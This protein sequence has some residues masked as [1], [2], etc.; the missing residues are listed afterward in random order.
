M[1]RSDKAGTESERLLRE[2][3]VCRLG[4]AAIG[5]GAE[6]PASAAGAAGWD[7]YPYVVPLHFAWDGEALYIHCAREGDKLRR[8]DQDNRVCIEIDE[9]AGIVPASLPCKVSSRYRSL[10]AF[11]R[12]EEVADPGQKSR[13]LTAIAVKYGGAAMADHTYTAKEL[14]AVT[15]LRVRPE[16]LAVKRSGD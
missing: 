8:L 13:A 12:A 5:H 14:E 6:A 3:P 15:V 7:G 2:A 11:G 1:R 4:F 10:I 16:D 9:F